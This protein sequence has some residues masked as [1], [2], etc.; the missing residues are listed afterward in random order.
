MET[1][2]CLGSRHWN[3]LWRTTHQVL[4]RL[5]KE[6]KI[7]Y[8]EPGRTPEGNQLSHAVN[9]LKNFVN[10]APTQALDNLTVVPGVP[11]IPQFRTKLPRSVLQYSYPT[12]SHINYSYNISY[13]KRAI[14]QL[15]I[16]DPI[17]WFWGFGDY[18]AA[19]PRFLK[20]IK[21]KLS[22]YL[23]YDEMAEFSHNKSIKEIL[24]KT[25]NELTKKVDFVLA[26]SKSQQARRLPLN[27][28]TYYMPNGVDFDHFN[29]PILKNVPPPADIEGLPGPI[30]GFSGWMGY[31]MDIPLLIKI[32]ERY[33][34]GS[35]V[36]VGPNEIPPSNDLVRF[37]NMPNV[38]FV[39]R[40][41][42]SELPAYFNSFNAALIPYVLEGHTKFIYPLKLHEYLA[43]GRAVV[44]T[45]LPNLYAHED[46]VRIAQNH[47]QFLELLAAAINDYGD[48]SLQ[49][50]F[51]LA[52]Q[53]SWDDRVAEVRDIIKKQLEAMSALST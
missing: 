41:L 3:S 32:A 2:I 31:Q 11:N 26:T 48:Q 42:P 51:D 47:D 44:S 5:S 35:V 17:L 39:G 24:S 52:K 7:V 30:I 27:Q 15:E 33:R 40:K 45:D 38:H 18:G 20:D 22:C 43:A 12:V 23:V 29:G 28:N 1:I 49:A 6:Y 53:Y 13:F 25:D 21:H 46:I 9:S 16:K 37:T 4:S 19:A 36:L 8:L 34:S 50:R 14:K 10:V